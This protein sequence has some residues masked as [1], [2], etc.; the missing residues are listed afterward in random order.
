MNYS[1]WSEN[2]AILLLNFGIDFGVDLL[3]LLL[4]RF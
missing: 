4:D 2:G 1:D 3:S